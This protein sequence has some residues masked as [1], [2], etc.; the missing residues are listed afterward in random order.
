MRKGKTKMCINWFWLLP[1]FQVKITWLRYFYLLLA[2]NSN[3]VTK[4]FEHKKT[5]KA[6]CI[7]WFLWINFIPISQTGP[8][9]KL[10]FPISNS[11]NV[12]SAI[13]LTLYIWDFFSVNFTRIWIINY[14]RLTRAEM[15]EIQLQ[16]SRK[17]NPF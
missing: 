10:F 16:F 13:E 12:F 11:T 14:A 9:K 4:R 8:N 17:Q 7:F 15:A 2:S 5:Q 3:Q 6:K 1:Q